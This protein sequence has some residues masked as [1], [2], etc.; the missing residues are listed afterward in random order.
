MFWIKSPK[1]F[2]FNLERPSP[3][4]KIHL[5]LSSPGSRHPLSPPFF[6]PA[7]ATGGSRLSSSPSP[8]PAPSLSLRTSSFI[9]PCPYLFF[10]SFSGEGSWTATPVSSQ[11]INQQQ[12]GGGSQQPPA[13][14]ANSSSTGTSSSGDHSQAWQTA[15]ASK[16]QL[17]LRPLFL[18][19]A[20]N[21]TSSSSSTREF[22]S[23]A[24]APLD[25]AGLEEKL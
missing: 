1:T 3:S 17:P 6:F 15:A 4:K 18:S 22:R 9:S 24:I 23:A 2:Q 19:P 13:A 5:F 10:S 16:S 25:R 7:K 20:S 21:R 12:R 8:S 11:R 14:A